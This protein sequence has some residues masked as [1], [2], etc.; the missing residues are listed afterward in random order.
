MWREMIIIY[1]ARHMS[2]VSRAERFY[3]LESCGRWASPETHKQPHRQR[4][5]VRFL[6]A[7]LCLQR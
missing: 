3:S 4:I 5:A 2:F 1:F 7:C 6:D